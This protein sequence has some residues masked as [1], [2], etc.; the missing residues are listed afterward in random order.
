MKARIYII[1]LFFAIIILPGECLAANIQF[2]NYSYQHNF[3][4][5]QT[6]NFTATVK[7]NTAS[8]ITTAYLVA[9]LT[10]TATGAEI[11]SAAS[12]PST[13]Q[14]NGAAI[15]F[16]TQGW[17]VLPPAG[18]YTVTLIIYGNG[19]IEQGRKY[20]AFPVRIG[21]SS[22][23]E[24]LQAFPT[25]LDFG[26]IPYGRHMHPI[27]L[28]ITWDFFLFNV[29]GKQQAWYM[30]I[31][32]DNTT[33]FKGIEN[34][35]HIA[36]PAGLVSS[37]GKYV[38]PLK[39]WCLNFPPDDQEMGWDT[40][41][42]GA[43]PVDDDTYWKGPM[44]DNGKRNEDKAAWLRIP[45]Y[46]EMT[47]DRGTWRNLI[48]QDITDTQYVTDVS[49]TGDFTLSSPFSAYLAT[50]TDPTSVKGSYSCNL[51]LEIYAP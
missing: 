42:S 32:T 30:R 48:G 18:K 3:T 45:D 14:N 17:A 7:N 12:L 41:L 50:E 28:E 35:V 34:A 44:L 29:Q 27:P 1:I 38:I 47:S 33:R 23:A 40:T 21:S 46:S 25:V 4:Y 31:Y 10:N 9:A 6:F 15:T 24:K 51:I 5:G 13:I 19:D 37:D 2:L 16:V 8:N 39:I 20:G 11:D 26:I 49:R 22:T 43:P 36:S